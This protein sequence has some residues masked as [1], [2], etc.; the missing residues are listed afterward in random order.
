MK[1]NK[2]K[3]KKKKVVYI[4]DDGH[5]VYSMD[6]LDGGR[7]S[8]KKDETTRLSRKERRAAIRAAFETYLP[9]FIVVLVCFTL[10]ALLLYFWI[11]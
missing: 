10:T 5:T 3:K 8:K 2:P 9:M 11:K 1:E 6:G 7:R 4:E